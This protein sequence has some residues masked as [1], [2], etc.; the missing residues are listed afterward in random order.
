VKSRESYNSTKKVVPALPIGENRTTLWS[1]V[2]MHY[3]R[4]LPATGFWPPSATVVST[5][6]CSHRTGTMRCLQ[7]EMATYRHWSVSLWRDPDDV[8]HCRILSHNGGLSQLHSADEDAVS[9]P[10]NY[11]SWHAHEA[12]KKRDCCCCHKYYYNYCYYV[13]TVIITNPFIR[14]ITITK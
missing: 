3:Q 10:T 12:K 11:G 5:E 2:L 9:W 14:L 4:A 6:L 8:P 13:I 1:L 7:K